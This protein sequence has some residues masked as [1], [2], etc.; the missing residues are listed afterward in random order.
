MFNEY[1]IEKIKKIIK[2]NKIKIM[3][4]EIVIKMNK[5][6][7]NMF[8]IVVKINNIFFV[9]KRVNDIIGIESVCKGIESINIYII[10][11]EWEK[12]EKCKGL[13]LLF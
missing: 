6:K 7:I 2:M 11:R 8:E 4:L 13:Y 1:F 12:S 5:I 9:R 3:I 10:Y